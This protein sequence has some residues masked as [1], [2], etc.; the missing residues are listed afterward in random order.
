MEDETKCGAQKTECWNYGTKAILDENNLT[1]PQCEPKSMF[2]VKKENGEDLP[3][4]KMETGENWFCYAYDLLNPSSSGDLSGNHAPSHR[5]LPSD[6]EK[7]PKSSHT[8]DVNLQKTE[9]RTTKEWSIGD[10]HVPKH[11]VE[12]DKVFPFNFQLQ[13]HV[14]VVHRKVREHACDECDREFASLS[15][16]YRH[17]QINHRNQLYMCPY[18]GCDHPGYKCCQG[19]RSHIRSV[20]TKVRPYVC[21]TCGKGFLT[22]NR[23][24]MH[25][26]THS[27]DS[28]FRCK[29]GVKYRQKCSLD[30]HQ[31]LCL[32]R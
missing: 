5:S 21:E 2:T 17:K 28:L 6:D 11:C 12:C 29:C 25:S 31:R 32:L 7:V 4:V 22:S 10:A 15:G 26:L 24:K 8:V 3:T 27:S 20:H 9:E 1:E 14:A 23:M 18:E 13:K 19:L 16:L 30:K